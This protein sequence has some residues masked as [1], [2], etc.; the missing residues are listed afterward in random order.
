MSLI[1]MKKEGLRRRATARVST[2]RKGFSECQGFSPQKGVTRNGLTNHAVDRW[3]VDTD[4][5]FTVPF[6]GK[7]KPQFA[8]KNPVISPLPVPQD[9][10]RALRSGA[11]LGKASGMRRF[12][13][14][15]DDFESFHR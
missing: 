12:R 6:V 5:S 10:L 15:G 3:L 11:T 8:P 13:G 14:L 1:Y 7:R 2:R 9:E 4:S